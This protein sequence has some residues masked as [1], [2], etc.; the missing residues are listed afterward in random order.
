VLEE[1][2][3]RITLLGESLNPI[4][5]PGQPR[6]L[7]RPLGIQVADIAPGH[8]H[9]DLVYLA[10]GETAGNGDGRWFDRAGIE[11]LDLTEEVMGWCRVALEF[12]V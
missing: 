4:E 7:A 3:V 5:R 6:Q 10:R 9:V 2:G 8:Q 12:A 11:R 1:T